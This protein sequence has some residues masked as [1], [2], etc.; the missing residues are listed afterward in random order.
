MEHW[1]TEYVDTPSGPRGSRVLWHEILSQFDLT[2]EA[3]P[4]KDNIVQMLCQGLHTLKIGEPR[5]FMAC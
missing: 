1:V 2:I 4:G 5:Y 3:S